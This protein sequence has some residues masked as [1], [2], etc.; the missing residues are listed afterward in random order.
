MSRA[1][2]AKEGLRKILA[3]SFRHPLSPPASHAARFVSIRLLSFWSGGV[4]V[5]VISEKLS[6]E[7]ILARCSCSCCCCC[8]CCWLAGSRKLEL[9][10]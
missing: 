5:T 4:L 2:Y 3:A 6:D 8:S 1:T 9:G 7:A 10:N